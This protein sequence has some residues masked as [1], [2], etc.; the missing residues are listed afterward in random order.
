MYRVDNAVIMAAGTS[1]RFAPLSY[2]RPKAL[3][4]V[5]GEVLIERQIRQ[6]REA[7]ID[8][9]YVVTGYQAKQFDYLKEKYGVRMIYNP[10]YLLRNNHA[11]IWWARQVIRNSYICSADNYFSINPFDREVER[12]YYAAVYAE[13]HTDEWCMTEKDGIIHSVTIGGRDAWCM[14]GHVFWDENF[15]KKFLTILEQI[16]DDP[17]TVDKL[18][19]RIYIDHIRELPMAIKKYPANVIYEFDTLDELRQFDASYIDDTR[20]VVLKK[21]CRKLGVKE[22][23]VTNIRA[24]KG[25]DTAAVG[26]TFQCK[27]RHYRFDYEKE[28]LTEEC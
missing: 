14:L 24:C 26:F 10:D 13:G 17:A 1:S 19:E 12:A 8:D 7:G 16:Y 15:S 5:K 9:L 18:W 3:T 2:E 20:S 21:I 23:E 6:L 4:E 27:D 25:A 22:R 11:S 28:E